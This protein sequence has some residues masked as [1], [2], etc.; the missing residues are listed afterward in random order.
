MYQPETESIVCIYIIDVYVYI[1]MYMYMLYKFIR[2][3]RMYMQ[4]LQD[5]QVNWL[6]RHYPCLGSD[7][8][9]RRKTS[10]FFWVKMTEPKKLM[11]PT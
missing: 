10:G 11:I 7:H 8:P 9:G 4:K 2:F 1:Y 6:C 3:M 5:P